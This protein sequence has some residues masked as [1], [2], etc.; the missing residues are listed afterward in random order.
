MAGHYLAARPCFDQL[1]IPGGGHG[2]WRRPLSTE[3][4]VSRIKTSRADL[5]PSQEVTVPTMSFK[6]EG[7]G[8]HKGITTS[9]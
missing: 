4:D 2:Q 3:F 9:S 6:T 1:A 5:V 8:T 7:I